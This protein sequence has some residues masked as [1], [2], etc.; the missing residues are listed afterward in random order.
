MVARRA[1]PQ[2]SCTGTV[3]GPRELRRQLDGPE[4][5]MASDLRVNSIEGI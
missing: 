2:A 3:R 4:V 5:S 1:C